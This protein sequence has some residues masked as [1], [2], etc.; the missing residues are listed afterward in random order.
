MDRTQRLLRTLTKDARVVEI[1][2]SFRPL[3]PKRDGWNTF[4]VDHASRNDLVA[5][6][7]VDHGVDISQ[8][9][10]VDFVWQGGSLAEAV[11]ADQHGTFDAFIASHVIEHTTDVVT[12]LKAAETLIR[13]DGVIILAVPDKRKCFDFYRHPSTTADAIVAFEEKRDRHDARTHLEY[14]MR[15]VHKGGPG[16]HADDTRAAVICNPLERAHQQLGNAAVSGYIDAH[17]WV[18]VPASFN[19]IVVELGAMGYLDLCIE[20]IA[21][22]EASEFYA[23]LRRG[24]EKIQ[25]IDLEHRRQEL[26]DTIIFEQAQQLEQFSEALLRKFK[27]RKV[28]LDR[29]EA[30]NFRAEATRKVLS[31]VLECVGWRGLDRKKFKRKIAEASRSIPDSGPATVQHLVLLEEAQKVLGFKS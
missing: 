8:I 21:E 27:S 2:P 11:P 24:K 7:S 6:Y 31:A 23:W 14:T 3:A 29:L 25:S 5:K 30:A 28:S 4:V 22:A 19:L 13:P 18:F 17:N 20:E 26:M 1:G 9:E 16:W 10:E 15:A 12:F